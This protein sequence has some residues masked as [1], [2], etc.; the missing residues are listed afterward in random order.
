MTRSV[1]GLGNAVYKVE[2]WD[3]KTPK[4]VYMEGPY[5]TKGAARGRLTYMSG[6]DYYGNVTVGRVLELTG[7]WK[8]VA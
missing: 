7:E 2:Y 8:E 3:V 1:K 6:N 4:V 5:A